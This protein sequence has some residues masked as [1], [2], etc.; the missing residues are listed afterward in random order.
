[1]RRR[2]KDQEKLSQYIVVNEYCQVF[3]GL[4]GG[5]PYFEE[6]WQRARTLNNLH[7]FDKIKRGT[8][9]KL[10]ILYL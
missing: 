3:A 4:K 1:M 2:K 10:E 8:L 6:D 9:D 7:Q 5:Y